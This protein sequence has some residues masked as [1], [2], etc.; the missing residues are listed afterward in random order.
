MGH[1]PLDYGTIHADVEL[2]NLLWDGESFG[3][4]DFDEFVTSWRG[5]EI[6]KALAE[7]EVEE[8]ASDPRGAAFVTGYRHHHDLSDES[9]AALPLMTRLFDLGMYLRLKRALAVPLDAE[10]SG[11][12]AGVVGNL[13]GW[14]NEFESGL[15][16]RFGR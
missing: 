12:L 1:S 11:P 6:A 13:S 7:L 5:A 15:T 3:F 10:G 16:A 2:D 9:L 14:M 4:I 8:I